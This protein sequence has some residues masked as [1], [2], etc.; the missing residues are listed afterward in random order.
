MPPVIQLESL[1]P[2]FPRV[3]SGEGDRRSS[4]W[5]LLFDGP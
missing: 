2:F 5:Q 4:E 1:C 3:I